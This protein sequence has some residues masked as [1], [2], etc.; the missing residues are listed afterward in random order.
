[1][2]V[3]W[4][5]I[6]F[7]V[8]SLYPSKT[9]FNSQTLHYSKVGLKFGRGHWNHDYNYLIQSTRVINSK[10]LGALTQLKPV[11]NKGFLESVYQS[12][13]S[14]NI[15]N[16]LPTV[17]I[18]HLPTPVDNSLSQSDTLWLISENRLYLF[19]TYTFIILVD[20][21]SSIYL[22]ILSSTGARTLPLNVK[23]VNDLNTLVYT[24][25]QSIELFEPHK[26]KIFIPSDIIDRLQLDNEDWTLLA[27]NIANSLQLDFIDPQSVDKSILQINRDCLTLVNLPD[28]HIG[29]HADKELNNFQIENPSPLF[30][31]DN[32][33]NELNVS[34]DRLSHELQSNE[35]QSINTKKRKEIEPP[36]VADEAPK[37]RLIRRANK[38]KKGPRF[39]LDDDDDQPSQINIQQQQSSQQ[40]Q[41]SRKR[42]VGVKGGKSINIDD[43]DEDEKYNIPQYAGTVNTDE[44]NNNNNNKL[45]NPPHPSPSD[46]NRRI[47]NQKRAKS[48]SIDNSEGEERQPQQRQTIL[49]R[50]AGTM[51]AT[52]INID[53]SD[54]DGKTGSR[55]IKEQNIQDTANYDSNSNNNNKVSEFISKFRNK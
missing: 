24:I 14:D 23:T 44:T 25:R 38:D 9:L 33:L 7:N 16:I 20:D 8:S 5:P 32:K 27:S 12:L 3:V 41:S 1:M 10:V 37:K 48:I 13:L 15:Q 18:D 55:K 29:R 50:R 4:S 49:G 54:E 30:N 45:T 51:R 34:S 28:D 47:K 40:L 36:S 53:D 46:I 21:K 39:N 11:V 42:R 52:S 22:D 43:S 2:K 26:T 35:S 17:S 6:Y 31:E 19:Q